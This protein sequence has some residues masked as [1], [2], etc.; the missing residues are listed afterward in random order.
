[1]EIKN[2]QNIRDILDSFAN[3]IKKDKDVKSALVLIETKDDMLI[4]VEGGAKDLAISLYELCK[5][6]PQIRHVLKVVLLILEK[7]EQ[8][9][10]THEAN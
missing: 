7:E 6:V 9:K 5:A 10:A 2:E 1:M 3:T 8:A 4:H